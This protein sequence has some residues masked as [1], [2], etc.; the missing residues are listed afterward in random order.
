MHL[1]KIH[2]LLC[3]LTPLTRG[4]RLGRVGTVLLT[5]IKRGAERFKVGEARPLRVFSASS[6][7]E[8]TNYK[9]ARECLQWQ[10]NHA[11]AAVGGAGRRG[12]ARAKRCGE[13][14]R[15][16]GAGG[17]IHADGCVM[18]D[19]G[20]DSL[21]INVCCGGPSV[22]GLGRL[23]SENKVRKKARKKGRGRRSRQ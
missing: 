1:I 22:H 18:S 20:K 16:R 10:P 11:H 2:R 21:L 7:G 9:G 19:L 8:N 23:E 3:L 6:G 13:R 14:S 5:P 4:L 12:R 15:R 17:V